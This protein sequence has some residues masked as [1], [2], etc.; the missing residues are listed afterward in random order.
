MMTSWLDPKLR[1]RFLLPFCPY[2]VAECPLCHDSLPVS[3]NNNLEVVFNII[4]R[5]RINNA[6]ETPRLL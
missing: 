5:G 4:M 3:G 6:D 1:W 2:S